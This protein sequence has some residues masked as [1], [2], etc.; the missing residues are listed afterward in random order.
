MAEDREGAKSVNVRECCPHQNAIDF[1]F[2]ELDRK[3]QGRIQD[4]IEIVGPIREFPEVFGLDT[5]LWTELLFNPNIELITS[6]GNKGLNRIG[7]SGEPSCTRRTGEH[8]VL[9]VGELEILVRMKHEERY[10]SSGIDM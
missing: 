9:V 4:G 10:P 7:T 1:R 5:E 6:C 2:A 8:Q 3:I